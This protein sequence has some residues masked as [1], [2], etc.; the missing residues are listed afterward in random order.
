MILLQLET[1]LGMKRLRMTKT[2][3]H[4]SSPAL[5]RLGIWPKK[6]NWTHKHHLPPPLLHHWRQPH[7][8]LIALHSP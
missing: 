8:H 2:S 3:L 4:N 5:R 7:P 1:P 6:R